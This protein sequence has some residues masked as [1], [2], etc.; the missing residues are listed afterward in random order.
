MPWPP[1]P[2]PP[3]KKALQAADTSATPLKKGK[4]AQSYVVNKNYPLILAADNVPQQV[5]GFSVPE[6]T[7]L[8]IRAN[9]NTT[10]GNAAMIFV[11]SFPGAFKS[12]HGTPMT[13]VDDIPWP[14]SFGGH[15]WVYGKK[16]DGVVVSVTTVA[17][18]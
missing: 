14:S 16:G 10:A 7:A 8:R 9:N 1:P 3:I 12:G 13:A 5:P 4:G 18:L 2:P 15:I 17:G 11:A 6:G